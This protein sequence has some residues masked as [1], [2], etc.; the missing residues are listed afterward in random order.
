MGNLCKSREKIVLCAKEMFYQ[1]GYPFTS[2]DDILKRCGVA[3]SNFY[4]HFESKE[5]LALEVLDQWFADQEALLSV[6]TDPVQSPRQRLNQF[7][8]I[9]CRA[10]SNERNMAGCPFGNFVASLPTRTADERHERFRQRLDQLL[11]RTQNALEACFA[12]G[13][14]HGEF[15]DDISPADMATLFMA[16]IQGLSLLTK[17]YRSVASMNCGFVLMLKLLQPL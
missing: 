11:T 15:R 7:T 14:Q 9:I 3:K 4:Y 2:I 1:V 5:Q 16:T 12:E 13:I 17:T 6:L 8:D 10:Q